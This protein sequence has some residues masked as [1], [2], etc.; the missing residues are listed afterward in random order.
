MKSIVTMLEWLMLFPCKLHN[1]D[2]TTTWSY[3]WLLLLTH[4]VAMAFK[5]Q[6][7]K[8]PLKGNGQQDRSSDVSKRFC[9]AA[10][11]ARI[12]HASDPGRKGDC[13]RLHKGIEAFL[14]LLL[15]SFVS[16][17]LSSWG[18]LSLGP[19]D[20]CTFASQF[21]SHQF[22]LI[23]RVKHRD[24][25]AR[26]CFVHC[27]EYLF[28]SGLTLLHTLKFSCILLGFFVFYFL[29]TENLASKC[30]FLSTLAAGGRKKAAVP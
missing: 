9:W 27:S 14:V 13:K 18:L 29:Y 12:Q 28:P 24:Q 5:W 6:H 17:L 26:R 30:I 3:Q 19:S 11:T 2:V 10:L 8:I 7:H 15:T 1:P 4:Y 23:F 25:V 22:F 16:F 20:C 21:F